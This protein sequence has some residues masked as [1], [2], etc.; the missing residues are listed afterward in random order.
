MKNSDMPAMPASDILYQKGLSKR[1][2]FAGL[3]IQGILANPN[4][5]PTTVE[6]FCN[7][8]EDALMSADTLLLALEGKRQ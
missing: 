2:Y 4:C 1:E 8:A 7:I 3:A 6:H 5:E